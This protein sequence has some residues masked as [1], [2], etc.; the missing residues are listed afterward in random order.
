MLDIVCWVVD[1]HSYTVLSTALACVQI[2]DTKHTQFLDWMCL[3][4]VSPCP[5]PQACPPNAE[6]LGMPMGNWADPIP[7]MMSDLSMGMHDPSSP[8]H[9]P[10]PPHGL[11]HSPDSMQHHLTANSITAPLPSP[12]SHP[13]PF[14]AA[15]APYD[16][17]ALQHH[18]KKLQMGEGISSG[19]S[20]G[21]STISSLLDSITASSHSGIGIPQ[22]EGSFAP[23]AV[24]EASTSYRSHM[25]RTNSNCSSRLYSRAN[26]HETYTMG[27]SLKEGGMFG[28]IASIEGAPFDIADL[29][30]E[31]AL[32]RCWWELLWCSV[33]CSVV[34]LVIHNVL[35]VLFHC[36]WSMHT[37]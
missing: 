6:Q 24:S 1:V 10:Y 28:R 8:Q 30:R 17:D 23:E 29:E 27:S 18:L 20:A 16:L 22:R 31:E 4:R 26:S 35:L 11:H 37:H 15:D 14:A 32:R 2:F 34:T 21:P 19:P 33:V 3:E 13:N 25:Y 9:P 7:R 5:H 36:H 12:L